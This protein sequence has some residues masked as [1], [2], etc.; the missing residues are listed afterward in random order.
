MKC[1]YLIL[2]CIIL[3][4][5]SSISVVYAKYILI[6]DFDISVITKPFYFD[7]VVQQNNVEL[8]YN[9]K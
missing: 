5:I 4:C 6:R 2:T 3:I 1:K 8:N 7:A 9:P